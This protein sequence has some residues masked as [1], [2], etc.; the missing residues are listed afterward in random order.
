VT[1]NAAW[2]PLA[3]DV[4]GLILI[5]KAVLSPEMFLLDPTLPVMPFRNEV[6]PQFT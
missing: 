4:D 3:Q 2:G 6:L 5:M 1:V